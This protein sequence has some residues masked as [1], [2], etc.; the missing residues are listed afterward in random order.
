MDD[1]DKSMVWTIECSFFLIYEAAFCWNALNFRGEIRTWLQIIWIF[2]L[3]YQHSTKKW[4]QTDVLKSLLLGSHL[5][6][7]CPWNCTSWHRAL[8]SHISQLAQALG[9]DVSVFMSN[10]P[11]TSFQ[12]GVHK[13]SLCPGRIWNI[14]KVSLPPWHSKASREWHKGTHLGIHE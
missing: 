9:A 12:K 10:T 2:R 4:R 8:S 14:P 5:Q 1:Y 13:A 3:N 11:N 7:F 6:K